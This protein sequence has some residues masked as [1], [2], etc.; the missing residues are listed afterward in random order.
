MKLPGFRFDAVIIDEAAQAVEPST[1]IPFKFNPHRVV[2][3]GDPCQ[4]PAT[5][6]SPLT[7]RSLSLS[8]SLSLSPLCNMQVGDPCQLPATVFSRQAKEAGYGR[9]LFQRL[10]LSGMPV[11]ML[12]TQVGLSA[13]RRPFL[14]LPPII[15]SPLSPA[16]PCPFFPR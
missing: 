13:P 9:S 12:E 16:S 2:M 7:A 8:L 4:L 6:F 14:P 11:V 5:V 3:V 15:S 10:H 1:L